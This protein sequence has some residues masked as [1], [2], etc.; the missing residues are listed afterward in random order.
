MFLISEKVFNSRGSGTELATDP[1]R[2]KLQ[3]KCSGAQTADRKTG[4]VRS[5]NGHQ[6]NRLENPIHVQT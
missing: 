4:G 1:R 3:T 6:G 2:A 5:N